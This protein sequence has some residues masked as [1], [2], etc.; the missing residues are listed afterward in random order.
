V[1]V[2]ALLVGLA[3][4]V[5]FVGYPLALV[6]IFLALRTRPRRRARGLRILR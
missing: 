3:A 2:A 5:P 1:A 6:A 4:M